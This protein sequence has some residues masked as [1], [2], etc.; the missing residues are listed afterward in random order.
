[1]ALNLG[2]ETSFAEDGPAVQAPM[3]PEEIAPHFPQLEILECLGRG[4]MGVVYK[5][6]QRS[7]NRLVALKLLAPERVNN[8]EFAERFAREAQALAALN[9]PNIVTIHDFGQA[10]GFYFLLM[11]L[12]DGVNLGRL[13]REHHFT[14][15]EAL[16]IVPSI[17]DALQFAHDRGIVHRDIKPENLL[18]DKS[19]RVKVADFGLAKLVES[20]GSQH[21]SGDTNT[22][23]AG[24][25]AGVT[26]APAQ[27]L[28]QADG[29]M[30]TPNYMAPEQARRPAEVDHRADIY[31]LGVVFYQML[32]GELPAQKVEPPSKKV[33]IDVRLDEVVL[34][35]L[36]KN[37]ELRYQQA[38]ALKTQIETITSTQPGPGAAAAASPARS[39]AP[40]GVAINRSRDEPGCAAPGVASAK[41]L[42]AAPA[43]AMMAASGVRIATL[44]FGLL[45][46]V[47]IAV[48]PLLFGVPH[49]Q[50]NLSFP[51][52]GGKLPSFVPTGM[53]MGVA[54][55]IVVAWMLICLMAAV[56][57]LV[58][59]VR[60][61]QQ[62]HYRL[63][64]TGVILLLAWSL[65]DLIPSGL[66]STAGAWALL[67]LGVGIWALVVLRRPDVKRQFDRRKTQTGQ[68]V[69]GTPPTRE[70]A[71]SELARQQVATPAVGLI[72][73]A[74]LNLLVLGALFLF[75]R[76]KWESSNAV[77]SLSVDVLGFAF[78]K[79]THPGSGMHP[80]LAILLQA[81]VPLLICSSLLTAIGAW[82]M[83]QLRTYGL[84][85]AG[86]LLALITP[87]GLI[88]GLIFGPWAVLVLLRRNVKAAFDSVRLVR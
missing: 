38:S 51:G 36:E 23:T 3:A 6:R 64:I 47:L 21:L 19:G 79:T 4:G 31:A 45:V 28:T 12:V 17:C 48:L 59:G 68:T 9:H 86:A 57:A 77:E 74:V 10:G 87:P 83:R 14:P 16:A 72:V 69:S 82:R 56:V 85:H 71:A 26:A 40:P 42:I 58:G 61:H 7:L 50:L 73:V 27:G 65:L 24:D 81:L 22:R 46:T 49:N 35:A 63:A 44:L 66:T 34:R 5:A 30:G 67:D 88:L 8:P 1:M 15:E 62:R 76:I 13:M 41:W 37:P 39:E 52:W 18:L 53:V 78:S 70:T 84:A 55:A 80:W 2:T 75:V 54:L 25:N 29:V 33:Q 11:E 60:M 20:P 32:T 43:M